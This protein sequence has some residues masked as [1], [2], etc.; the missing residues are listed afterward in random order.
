MTII[1]IINVILNNFHFYLRVI[2]SYKY[3]WVAAAAALEQTQER[4]TTLWNRAFL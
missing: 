1:T 4:V 3:F 2:Q